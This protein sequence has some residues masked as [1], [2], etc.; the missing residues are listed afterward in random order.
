MYFSSI[1]SKAYI[2]CQSRGD[3]FNV[4]SVLG[5]CLGYY[6]HMTIVSF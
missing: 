2:V 6:D 1:L 3:L 4:I 5:Y